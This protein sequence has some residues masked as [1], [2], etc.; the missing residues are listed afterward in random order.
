MKKLTVL[1]LILSVISKMFGQETEYLR[2]HPGQLHYQYLQPV[3]DIHFKYS[4]EE[5]AK[6]K[7]EQEAIVKYIQSNEGF[8]NP[9]GV[10]ISISGRIQDQYPE[11]PWFTLIPSDMDVHFYPWFMFEGKP[12]FRCSECSEYFN[13]HINSPHY[14]Y[15]G[16]ASPAGSDVYDT[17]GSLINFEP[18]KIMEQDG[19]TLYDNNTI[20]ISKIGVPL[21]IPLTVR[22]YD[23]VL[24]KH[25]EKL[26]KDKPEDMM[27]HKFFY[28]KLKEEMS[29]FSEEDLDKPAYEYGFGGSPQPM[30]DGARRIVKINKSY[31]NLSKSRADV[32]LIVIEYMGVQNDPEKPYFQD[33]YSS[34]QK[35][36]LVEALKSFKFMGLIQLLR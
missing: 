34:F 32:Q 21:Y 6:V 10:E 24:L 1:F 23:N 15:N 25:L 27:T 7:A 9:V 31:F 19:A 22:Q 35:I 20:V 30:G 2:E 11:F 29:Q 33:E 14:L 3:G 16:Q 4:K 17:D 26:M 13:M 8:S 18:R 12:K 36:K 28:D 5:D